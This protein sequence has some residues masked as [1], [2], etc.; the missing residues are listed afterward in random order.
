LIDLE[1]DPKATKNVA[2][3]PAHEQ[4]LKRLAELAGQSGKGVKP[5]DKKK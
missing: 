5:S 2:A 3:D 1:A 4:L